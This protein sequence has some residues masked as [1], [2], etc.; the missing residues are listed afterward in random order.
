MTR[1][2]VLLILTASLSACSD[3]IVLVVSDVSGIPCMASIPEGP[4]FDS[5]AEVAPALAPPETASQVVIYPRAGTSAQCID[6]ASAAA[7]SAGKDVEIRHG[8]V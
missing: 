1:F 6:A 7:R 3:E 5:I 2:V 4:T 8:P